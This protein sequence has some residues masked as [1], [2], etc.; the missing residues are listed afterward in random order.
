M[1]W[2][3]G[4]NLYALDDPR[5]GL[6]APVLWQSKIPGKTPLTVHGYAWQNPQPAKRIRE[7]EFAS[8]N[9]ASSLILF[10][11]GGYTKK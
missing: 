7:I 3:L 1:L 10:G 11:L 6:A 4:Q 2:R 9:Q 8:A 5:V